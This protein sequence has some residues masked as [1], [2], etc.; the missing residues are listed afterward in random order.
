MLAAGVTTLRHLF[1]MD[2]GMG[3]HNPLGNVNVKDPM[4]YAKKWPSGCTCN[5]MGGS[6]PFH[7][8]PDSGTVPQK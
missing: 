5:P 8:H 6:S 3:G 7:P 2:K 1:L 4:D